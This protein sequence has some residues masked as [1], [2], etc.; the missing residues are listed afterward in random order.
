MTK[1]DKKLV[2]S[3][4]SCQIFNV[5]AWLPSRYPGHELMAEV[6]RKETVDYSVTVRIF[7]TFILENVL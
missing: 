7:V 3:T 2:G 4:P 6:E 5:W 1:Q